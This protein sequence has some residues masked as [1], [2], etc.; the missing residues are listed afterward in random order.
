MNLTILN[1]N[2]NQQKPAAEMISLPGCNQWSYF[3][4]IVPKKDIKKA[5]DLNSDLEIVKTCKNK[6]MMRGKEKAVVRG[7]QMKPTIRIQIPKS[8]KP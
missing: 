4:E 6:R 2:N 3:S 1:I 7:E 5:Y 8:P